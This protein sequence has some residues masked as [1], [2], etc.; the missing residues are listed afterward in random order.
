[1]LYNQKTYS[2]SKGLLLITRLNFK[3]KTGILFSRCRV[4]QP[5]HGGIRL[6]SLTKPFMGG[7]SSSPRKMCETSVS[8]HAHGLMIFF[9]TITDLRFSALNC[10]ELPRILALSGCHG[11]DVTMVMRLSRLLPPLLSLI[12]YRSE[13]KILFLNDPD[14]TIKNLNMCIV[15]KNS[16]VLEF[17][18]NSN[19]INNN[20]SL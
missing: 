17:C 18:Q 11:C 20:N 2:S 1:M 19:N 15:L 6:P 5:N 4:L 13:T 10:N 3:E 9:E 7:E 14:P 16:V 12:Y 8:M